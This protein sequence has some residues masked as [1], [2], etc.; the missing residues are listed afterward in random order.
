MFFM[1]SP[2]LG[3]YCDCSLVCVIA[4]WLSKLHCVTASSEKGLSEG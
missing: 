3:L 4:I 1:V 2:L